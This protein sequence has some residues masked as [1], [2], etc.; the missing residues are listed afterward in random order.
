MAKLFQFF[1]GGK[2]DDSQESVG[3][4]PVLF[5]PKEETKPRQNSTDPPT[6]V[7]ARRIT[8]TLK[9]HSPQKKCMQPAE[10]F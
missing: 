5:V 2:V 10:M 9:M 4:K 3:M 7:K 1:L 6:A 8:I